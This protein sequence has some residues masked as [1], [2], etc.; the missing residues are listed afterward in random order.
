[1]KCHLNHR[2]KYLDQN[3]CKTYT[4][5]WCVSQPL[6]LESDKKVCNR[7]DNDRSCWL[8]VHVY[9]LVCHDCSHIYDQYELKLS[10]SLLSGIVHIG[11]S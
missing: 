8:L 3:V 7:L 4:L 1:M 9:V 5:Q 6:P 11:V 10:K 2:E